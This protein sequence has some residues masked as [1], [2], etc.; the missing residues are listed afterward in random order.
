MA[1]STLRNTSELVDWISGHPYR[2][3]ALT[4]TTCRCGWNGH[5]P[6]GDDTTYLDHHDA[7]FLADLGDV[8]PSDNTDEH[9]NHIP[10]RTLVDQLHH[11]INMRDIKATNHDELTRRLFRA[12]LTQ[13]TQPHTRYPITNGEVDIQQQELMF[14]RQAYEQHLIELATIAAATLITLE[15]T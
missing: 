3:R 11:Y 7:A 15:K 5:N 4:P 10:W 12:F 14:T 6:H 9:H 13:A 2:H 1:S 8:L